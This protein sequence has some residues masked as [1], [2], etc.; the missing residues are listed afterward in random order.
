MCI[1]GL[2]QKVSILSAIIDHDIYARRKIANRHK[3]SIA[4][5]KKKL[6]RTS[7]IFVVAAHLTFILK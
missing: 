6:A 5:K 4:N 2:P 3:M 1:I 7:S